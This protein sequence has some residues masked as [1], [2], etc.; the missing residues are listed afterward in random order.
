MTAASA[1]STYKSRCLVCQAEIH[2]SGKGRPREY[3]AVCRRLENLLSWLENLICNLPQTGTTRHYIK[4]RLF[5]ISNLTNT[6]EG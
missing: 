1:L 5:T 3:H 4:S 2:Q 6:M